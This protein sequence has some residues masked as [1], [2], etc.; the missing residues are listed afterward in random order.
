MNNVFSAG[1]LCQRTLPTKGIT[2]PI[3]CNYSLHAGRVHVQCCAIIA[4]TTQK[5]QIY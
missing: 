2:E 4:I 1:I 5:T 3:A